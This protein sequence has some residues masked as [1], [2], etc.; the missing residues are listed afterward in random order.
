MRKSTTMIGI[1]N[2]QNVKKNDDKY[3]L[4]SQD[5]ISQTFA[6]NDYT[7][8]IGIRAISIC[9][10]DGTFYIFLQIFGRVCTL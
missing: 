8:L 7:N 2:V 6:L 9:Q 4:L 1:V 3:Q 10:H 5:L